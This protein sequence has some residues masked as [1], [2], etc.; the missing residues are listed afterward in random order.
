MKLLKFFESELTIARTKEEIERRIY[1]VYA[2][3]ENKARLLYNFYSSIML[4]GITIV[5][6]RTP[7]TTFYRNIKLLK[8]RV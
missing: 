8:E 2:N 7:R 4:D 6:A 5:K 1:T 3:N